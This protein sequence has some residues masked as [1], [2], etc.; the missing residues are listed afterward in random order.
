MLGVTGKERTALDALIEST[1][2]LVDFAQANP[3]AANF[4]QMSEAN[5]LGRPVA[6]AAAM[7]GGPA[8][9]FRGVTREQ[10]LGEP[11]I[12][13]NSNAAELRPRALRELHDGEG[14]PVGDGDLTAQ[15]SDGSAA[16]FDGDKLVASY[17][18]GD[19]LVVDKA[20]RRRGIGENW[21]TSGVPGI[22]RPAWRANARRHRRRCR[23]RCGIASSPSLRRIRGR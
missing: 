3:R 2:D 10:F 9:A 6:D 17:N 4:A 11:R 15:Y 13:A 19:T 21:C 5:R 22:R 23:K 18:F 14:D 16:V 7:E 8:E 12:T 1:S 20:Y